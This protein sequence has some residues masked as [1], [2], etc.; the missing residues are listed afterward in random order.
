[1]YLASAP[2]GA[3]ELLAVFAPFFAWRALVVASPAFY[4]AFPAAARD[5]LLA[6]VERVLDAP[7]FDPSW[8][9]ALFP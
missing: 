2:D 8:A 6:L 7:R 5:A 9:E 4:P 3:E 1:V